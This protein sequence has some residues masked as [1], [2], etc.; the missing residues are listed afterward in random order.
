MGSKNKIAKHIL[1]I[2]LAERKPDQWWVEPFVGGANMID[3][4]EG[5]RLGND[6]NEYLIALLISVRDGWVPPTDISKELYQNIKYN[7]SGYPP[8][9]VGF[10]GLLCSFGGKWFDGYAK[11]S[12]GRNYAEQGR[13]VL[14]KQSKNLSGVVFKSGSYLE[15]VIPEKSLIYCDPPYA[16]TKK[17]RDSLDHNIFWEWCRTQSKNG[18]TVFISEYTAPNDFIC[19]KEIEHVSIMNKNKAKPT[20]EK[21]FI[22]NG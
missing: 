3:K 21:L 10:V 17:Y 4:V 11:D 1:P 12:L 8:D 20:V 9:L 22:Y 13:R 18:H 14:V 16:N 5:N 15:L 2:M 7:K 19:I 6:I